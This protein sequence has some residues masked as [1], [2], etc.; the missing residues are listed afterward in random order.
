V[1]ELHIMP[2]TPIPANAIS[3]LAPSRRALL[4]GGAALAASAVMPMPAAAPQDDAL[5]ALERAFEAA[6]AAHAAALRHYQ[7]CEQRFFAVCPDPSPMLTRAGPLARLLVAD[8]CWLNVSDIRRLL[9]ERKRHPLT[10]AARAA[11]PVAKAYAARIRRVKRVVG[12]AAAEAAQFA[13]MDALDALSERVAA[14]PA[15]SLAGLA[16][17]AAVVKQWA[18]PHWWSDPGPAETLA[19]HVLDAAARMAGRN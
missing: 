9:R 10:K 13:A 1:I 7:D 4:T 14:E 5:H 15:R 17:K 18:A 19:A 3:V 8:W 11:L 12:L 16:V 6:L 2:Q